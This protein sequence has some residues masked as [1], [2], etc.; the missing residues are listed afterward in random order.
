MKSSRVGRL[1]W[2]TTFVI[3]NLVCVQVSGFLYRSGLLHGEALSDA[4][5]Q[6]TV[7]L[8][9]ALAAVLYVTLAVQHHISVRRAHDRDVKP[10]AFWVYAATNVVSFATSFAISAS[11]GSAPFNPAWIWAPPVV[12]FAW[13][14]L[15]F[16]AR[17][18][19][20]MPNRWGPVPRHPFDRPSP[21]PDNYRPP[22][23]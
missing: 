7:V 19:D 10:I 1:E 14:A 4:S 9:L 2:W 21:K 11:G 22:Q 17:P 18:G 12:A 15:E 8:G 23:I 3:A 6:S 20:P 13:A 5:L 16:G